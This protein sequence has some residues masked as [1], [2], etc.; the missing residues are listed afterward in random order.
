VAAELQQL[1]RLNR[2]CRHAAALLAC[3]AVGSVHAQS[4]AQSVALAGR[5]GDKALLVID[6]K[7]RMVAVGQSADGAKL[8]RWM[9]ENAEVEIP[10]GKRSLSVGGTPAQVGGTPT[11]AAAR[12]VVIAAG[13][14]GHFTAAGSIN[15]K[16][17]NFMVDTG[18]TLV[19]L[20][21][22][23]AER[24]G[25]DLSGARAGMSQTA[26]GAVPMFIVTLNSVRVGELELTNVGAAVM[27]MPM[28]MIL[29][30]N[31]FLS[32][33]QMRRENDVMRLEKR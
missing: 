33:T 25:I 20:G 8:L 26:N 17:V 15:G 18:A 1:Q 11:P 23:D 27:P 16:A 24:L 10:G 14:G 9:G 30:G 3:V 28:P 12:E 6:G 13:P 19:S 7:P 5:M 21:R 2:K 22:A 4:V 29:L 32:R 31:S